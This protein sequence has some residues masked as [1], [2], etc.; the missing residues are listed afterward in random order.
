M[1]RWS[2]IGGRF[3]WAL[4]GHMGNPLEEDRFPTHQSHEAY[5]WSRDARDRKRQLAKH[6]LVRLQLRRSEMSKP[7]VERSG[8]LGR[9]STTKGA[10]K[11]A[12]QSI[13]RAP[14]L[15]G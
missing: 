7:R 12:V 4:T 9:A 2:V 8:T 10:L 6:S 3:G 5:A 15:R 14:P 1:N 11:R 13:G